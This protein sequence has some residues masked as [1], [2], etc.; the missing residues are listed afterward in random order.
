MGDI[1]EHFETLQVPLRITKERKVS[2]DCTAR[3]KLVNMDVMYQRGHIKADQITW[4]W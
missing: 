3:L 4:W 2:E 1:V